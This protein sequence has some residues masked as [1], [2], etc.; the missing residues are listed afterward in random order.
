[1]HHIRHSHYILVI[2]LYVILIHWRMYFHHVFCCNV[3]ISTSTCWKIM[4]EHGPYAWKKDPGKYPQKHPLP[5]F[6]FIFKSGNSLLENQYFSTF[7][8]P[9]VPCW[10]IPTFSNENEA[11]GVFGVFPRIFSSCIGPMYLFDTEGTIVTLTPLHTQD[12]FNKL[13]DCV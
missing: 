2:I 13:S 7:Q 3:T 1:V 10:G 11:K 5:R 4:Y 6:G 12:Q 9:L 8:I